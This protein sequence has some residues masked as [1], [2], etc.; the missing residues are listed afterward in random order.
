MAC[1]AARRGATRTHDA[2]RLRPDTLQITGPVT[3]Y[4]SLACGGRHAVAVTEAGALWTAGAGVEGQ[5]GRSVGR[6]LGP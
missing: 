6:D 5:L 3:H 1:S 4:R 2:P